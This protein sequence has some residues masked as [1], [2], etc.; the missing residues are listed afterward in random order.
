MYKIRPD[1]VDL[2]NSSNPIVYDFKF[3]YANRTKEQFMRTRQMILYS[4]YGKG[5]LYI[6]K[7]S[8]G[9]LHIY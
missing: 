8:R 6:L 1:V 9:K 7:Y 5:G 4:A 2:T 3:G